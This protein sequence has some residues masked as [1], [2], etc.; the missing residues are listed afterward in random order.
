MCLLLLAA[1]PIGEP[2]TRYGPFVMTTQDE[3]KQAIDD[4]RSGALTR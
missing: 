2:V 4:F 3:I 1:K